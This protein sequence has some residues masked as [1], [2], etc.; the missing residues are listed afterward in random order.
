MI[1]AG[2]VRKMICSFPRSTDPL[3]FTELYRAGEIELELVPQGTL[4]ERIRAGG[5]GIRA[6]YTP[7]GLRHAAGRGQGDP[8]V[9][10]PQY[11]LERWLKADFALIKALQGR[12][13]GQPHLPQ[14]G[15]QLRPADGDGGASHHRAG[16]EIVELGGIDPEASSRPASSCSAWCRSQR[17]VATAEAA[18]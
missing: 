2:R 9:R 4:A 1:K 17:G 11:V 6:F 13:L 12:P 16:A 14:D 8:R 15:A 7:D 10:R 18:S 5:A 3:V